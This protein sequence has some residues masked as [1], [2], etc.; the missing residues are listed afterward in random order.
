MSDLISA[1]SLL[2]AA[3]TVLFSL[4]YPEIIGVLNQKGAK[5]AGDNLQLKKSLKIVLFTKSIPLTIL[6]LGVFLTFLPNVI[7]IILDSIKQG[8]PTLETYSAVNTAFCLVSAICLG[9]TFYICILS[10]MLVSKLCHLK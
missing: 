5:H 9:L 4:W 8:F 2:M 3:I 1:S 7:A 6:S 10:I